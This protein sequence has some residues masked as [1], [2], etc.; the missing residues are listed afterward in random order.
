M[1]LRSFLLGLSIFAKIQFEKRRGTSETSITTSRIQF[2]P[3]DCPRQKNL[4]HLP[5]GKWQKINFGKNKFK[6]FSNKTPITTGSIPKT[7]PRI[8]ESS[9]NREYA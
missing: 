9:E 7:F 2:H 6:Y 5:D 3:N 8:T 4:F 1:I